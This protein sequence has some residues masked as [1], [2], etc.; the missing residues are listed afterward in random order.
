MVLLTPSAAGLVAQ[1]RKDGSG[2]AQRGLNMG[3][4]LK[5]R[6]KAKVP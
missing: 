3:P 4:T 5:V 1:D 2:A 6:K